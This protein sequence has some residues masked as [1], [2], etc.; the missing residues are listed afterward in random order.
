MLKMKKFLPKKL[1]LLRAYV[2]FLIGFIELLLSLYVIVSIINFFSRKTL[3]GDI[4]LGLGGLYLV[5][6]SLS[7]L[8]IAQIILL[9]IGIYDNIDDMRKKALDENYT[10]DLVA[11]KEKENSNNI[12]SVFLIAVIVLSI[13]FS[14]LSLT[15]ESTPFA[16]NTNNS[17]SQNSLID[18]NNIQNE[19]K[20]ETSEEKIVGTP[21]NIKQIVSSLPSGVDE[22][23][24][25]QYDFPTQLNWD[26]AIK[27]CDA[28]GH[29]WRLPSK[30]ELNIL[31][32]YRDVIGGFSYFGY[33]S[34]NSDISNN[35]LAWVVDF[36]KY[37]Q[38]QVDHM[39]FKENTYQI[40]AV[41]GMARH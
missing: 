24:I 29:D 8:L 7:I 35:Q 33:F 13:V 27:A 23:E 40:R 32:E 22:F 6:V 31:R 28:L 38:V 20:T 10:V 12:H 30:E 19:Y 16:P 18:N 25:A 34:S 4:V 5:A 14:I 17:I 37:V 2:S 9:F 41:R 1:W 3:L 11:E 39:K 15:G 36:S 21:I 26:D